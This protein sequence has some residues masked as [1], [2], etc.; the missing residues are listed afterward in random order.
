[1]P[2][3]A[4]RAFDTRD[5]LTVFVELYDNRPNGAESIDRL[6]IV[7][8]SSGLSCSGRKRRFLRTAS[9]QLGIRGLTDTIFR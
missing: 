2:P 4:P 1:V 6:T 7:T 8:N 3:T 5:T 9:S